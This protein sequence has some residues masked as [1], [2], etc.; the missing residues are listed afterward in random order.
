VAV[1]PIVTAARLTVLVVAVAVAAIGVWR[2]TWAVGGSDSSCYALMAAS[3]ARGQLQPTSALSDAPWPDASRTLAP[4]GFFPSPM[5]PDAASPICMPGFSLLMAPLAFVGGRDAIFLLTPIAGAVLVWL[6]FMFGRHVAGEGAGAAAA[7]VLA[8]TPVF[9]FQV[10]QPMNDVMAATVWM[11]VLVLAARPGDHSGW[12][13]VLTGL[14]VLIRPNLAPA[15]AVV[16][17]W[18][19]FGG[20]RRFAA[21]AVAAAPCAVILAALNAALYGHPL[22][23]GYGAASE[24]FSPAHILPNVQNYWSALTET[25]LGFPLLGVLAVVVVP[26]ERRRLV[27]LALAVTGSIIVVYLLYTP[28]PEWWYLRFLL[29][30]LPVM[31]ALAMA[32]IVLG[33]RRPVLVWPVV[34]IV[35]GY[36]ASTEAMGQALEL[37]RLERRFR[38]VGEVVRDRLPANAVFVTV[39]DSGSVRYH[40]GREALLWDSLDPG[41]LDPAISWLAARGYEPFIIVEEWEEPLFR[42]RFAGRSMLGDLDWPPRYQISP[43]LRIF[44]PGDRKRYLAGEQI[45]TEHVR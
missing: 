6:T 42:E 10:V 29:P 31:T 15:A 20:I 12:I 25:Q 4:G 37:H 35:V 39:W 41:S 8:T 36:A 27:W 2:G 32:V 40:A 45:P 7:I 44:K 11:A 1:S 43:R 28:Y 24:L 5:R 9:V 13:G 17:T 23:T 18:C 14:A 34:V 19:L 33:T 21:F 22:R 30:V 38:T 26:R 16:A 3:F